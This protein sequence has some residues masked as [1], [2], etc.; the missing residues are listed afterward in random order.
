[1]GGYLAVLMDCL[2]PGMDGYET[3]RRIRSLGG[4]A[5]K[6]PI[7]ALTAAAM[8]GDRE[9][10]MAAGMDDYISKPLDLARLQAALD[11]QSAKAGIDAPAVGEAEPTSLDDTLAGFRRRFPIESFERICEEFLTSTPQLLADLESA[12]QEGDTDTVK[13]LAHK[14][15]GSMGTFGATR[16]AAVAR[17]LETE[18]SGDLPPLELVAQLKAEF[19]RAADLVRSHLSQKPAP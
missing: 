12:V 14:L 10:C 8:S 3:T 7:I 17:E 13:A 19:S 18:P 4:Q 1:H 2:M 5:Q 15:R 6:I 16:M 9:R 11:R